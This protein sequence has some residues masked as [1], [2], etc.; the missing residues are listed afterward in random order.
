MS[1][2][3]LREP[4]DLSPAEIEAIEKLSLRSLFQAVVDFGFDAWRI[5]HQSPDKVK[6][7][8]EDITRELL[9]RFSGYA[10]DQRLFG[11]VDYRKAR[12][13]FLPEYGVRQALFVDSKAEKSASS[14][15]MQM[16][17]LS[18]R[19][20]MVRQGAELDEAGLLDPV[21]IYKGVSFLTTTMLVH[22]LYSDQVTADDSTE[23][24]DVQ[25]D[26]RIPEDSPLHHFLKQVTIAAVPNGML[27]DFYNP[28]PL[29]TIW[30]VGRNA[31]QRGEDFRVR[32]AFDKLS[33]K[34]PWRVQRISYDPGSQSIS[35]DW[36]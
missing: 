28:D 9:D 17:Q 2:G 11:N 5:F 21:S 32:L 19:V 33:A 15:T 23:S 25:E 16:S 30:N 10:I 34:M 35:G 31:P 14:G 36:S 3:N 6:D 13:I 22:Y 29:N 20:K 27:Q 26:E 8:A 1:S 24:D 7:V 18:L 4:G 12:Y